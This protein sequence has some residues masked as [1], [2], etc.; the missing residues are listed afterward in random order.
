MRCIE[1]NLVKMPEI[2][3]NNGSNW[4]W[5]YPI[6]DITTL[7]QSSTA[8][9]RISYMRQL[10]IGHLGVLCRSTFE[11]ENKEDDEVNNQILM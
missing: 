10:W 4:T 2:M 7:W 9:T 8:Y 6:L 1:I 5:L 3:R 11:N